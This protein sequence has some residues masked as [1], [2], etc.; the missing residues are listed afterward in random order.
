MPTCFLKRLCF[1]NGLLHSSKQFVYIYIYVIKDIN[2]APIILHV[3]VYHHKSGFHDNG[4][5]KKVISL[6]VM[7]K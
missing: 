3:M 6:R 5:T 4:K 7:S 1:S 2:N